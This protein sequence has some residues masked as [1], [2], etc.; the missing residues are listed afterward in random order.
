M[1]TWVLFIFVAAGPH[2]VWNYP[3]E[4][5]CV[6]DGDKYKWASCVRVYIPPVSRK[7]PK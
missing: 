7:K 2:A 5:E 1:T 4:E 3:T 6:R